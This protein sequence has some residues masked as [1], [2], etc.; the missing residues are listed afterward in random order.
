MIWLYPS[1][2]IVFA[3][4][5]ILVEVFAFISEVCNLNALKQW[6]LYGIFLVVFFIVLCGVL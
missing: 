3:V 6:G 5:I 2:L 4:I 1:L